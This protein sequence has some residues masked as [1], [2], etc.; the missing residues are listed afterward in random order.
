MKLYE[1]IT[2]KL[3]ESYSDVCYAMETERRG[4]GP[5]QV[6]G[7][8]CTVGELIHYLEGLDEDMKIVTSHDDGYT[9]GAIDP[10]YDIKE[11]PIYD[12]ENDDEEDT[13]E[14]SE[15]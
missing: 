10:S 7:D 1:S 15:I 2:N 11:V 5:D 4:Y 3:T 8:T 12:D 14:D 13:E 9:Y 6:I